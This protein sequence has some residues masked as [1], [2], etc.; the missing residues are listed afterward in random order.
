MKTLKFTIGIQGSGKSTYTKDKKPVVSTDTL[1]KEFYG[2]VDD[3]SDE[4]FI[5]DTAIERI[6]GLFKEHNTVYFDATMVETK[7]RI[8]FLGK[9]KELVEGVELIGVIFS[10][11]PEVAK[12]RIMEDL[13]AGIDRADS[14]HYVDEYYEY[15]QE[16]MELIKAGK[17]MF[18]S[19]A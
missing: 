12:A 7:H 13:N 18:T 9:I 10:V 8:T 1:R 2:N 15:F 14:T 11:D 3:V 17:V 5:F 6:V 16:T 19:H 4:K